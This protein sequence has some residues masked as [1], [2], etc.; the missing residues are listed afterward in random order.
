MRFRVVIPR[1]PGGNAN[2]TA[3]TYNDCFLE[4][5]EAVV[6]GL[7]AIGHEARLDNSVPEA[8]P[9]ARVSWDSPQLRYSFN[10]DPGEVP[11]VFGG[12]VLPDGYR[13]G[14]GTIVYN[15]E[16]PNTVHMQKTLRLASQ[17]GVR[18]WE[19]KRAN[20]GFWDQHGVAYTYV[21][22]GY[23]PELTTIQPAAA[24]D[25]DC[26]FSGYITPNCEGGARR[27]SVLNRLTAA[28]AR[29]VAV[30]RAF[31]EERN[32]L[33]ARARLVLNIHFYQTF[34][35]N[36]V[37]QAL[38][39]RKAVLT[40]R[41]LDDADYG[42]LEGAIANVPYEG[43]VDEAMALLAAPA[44]LAELERR[45]FEALAAQDERDILRRA[46]GETYGA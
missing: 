24:K 25:I 12:N 35:I 23:V 2:W 20:F 6:H 27:L 8:P 1:P 21:P 41:S 13:L 37:V 4:Q 16:Q 40:E 26:F 42:W 9:G 45:G 31:G 11:I 10:D 15:L 38:A 46:L 39:N 5:A 36:R 19:Y 17:P 29:V 18:V 33:I 28:G 22:I 34:E 30:D 3:A 14:P 32:R 44:R 43:L 7:N